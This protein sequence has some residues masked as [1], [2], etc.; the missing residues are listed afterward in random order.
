MRSG[1]QV[2][3]APAAGDRVPW[4]LQALVAWIDLLQAVVALTG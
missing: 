4:L 2:D 1:G 3:V